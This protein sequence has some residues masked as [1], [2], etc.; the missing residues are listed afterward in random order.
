MKLKENSSAQ[1]LR[2]GYY[3]PRALADFIVKN[4]T[5]KVGAK[6]L[7]PSCGDGVFLDS[8]SEHINENMLE[9]I[10]AIEIIEEE[11][12]KVKQ[13]EYGEKFNVINND[14]LAFYHDNKESKYDLILG[15]PPYIRYQYLTQK[16]RN[17]Q[18]EILI[19]NGMKSNKLI[20]SWV[21]FL[22][23][24]VEMLAEG[25]TIGFVIPAEILQVVYAEDLRQY[26]SNNLSRI[27]L[28]TFKELVFPDIEQEVVVLIAEKDMNI[29][30]EDAVI[31]VV[32]YTNFEDMIQHDLSEVEYQK[33][34]HTKEKWTHYFLTGEEN[35]LIYQFRNHSDFTTFDKIALV[36]VGITTGNNK[37]FSVDKETVKKYELDDIVL[38]LI[39]RS[40]HAHGLFFNEDDWHKN[41]ENDT[42]AQLVL[43]PEDVAYSDYP[44]GY[45]K[46]IKWGEKTE[47]N[48]GYKCRIRDRWYIV[49]S[50]WTPDA[51][52]LRR[53]NIY[54][55]FVL[56]E[57]N[58]VS[59]DTM[60]RI[61]FKDNIDKRKALLSYY[62]SISFAFT[63]INGRSYGGGVLEILPREV[64]A[65]I[66]P[67]LQ[68]MEHKAV[69][70]LLNT[71]DDYIRNKKD[72]EELL[73]IIDRAVLIDYL[74]IEK[75]VISAFR[76]IWRKLMNRRLTRSR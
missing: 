28:L 11:A 3:T 25:G 31:S 21:C 64:G 15:N 33:I 22:V 61:K 70:D 50:V 1:K 5:F 8:I 45:K 56:N 34:E 67:D 75:D 59:T 66:L 74:G 53:N 37:Y 63:E 69:D 23:A 43:F 29:S 68:R 17:I 47:Q 54:P 55:K 30:T 13:R 76:G 58:A 6:A 46:Y 41:V 32:E 49:P 48:T 44:K 27:T 65:V 42:R 2:G 57:I 12:N 14:F 72:I 4:I 16:Q 10:D 35:K 51:F 40:A 24:C 71:I 39:G 36:N 52:F 62:N 9:S 38:P 7:E 73:D 26:L 19:S 60:H 18:S 20:N